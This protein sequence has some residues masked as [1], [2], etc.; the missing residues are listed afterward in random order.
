MD[1]RSAMEL[2]GCEIAENVR[3]ERDSGL[4]YVDENGANRR[5]KAGKSGKWRKM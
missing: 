4:K 2:H 3:I 5:K 1:D